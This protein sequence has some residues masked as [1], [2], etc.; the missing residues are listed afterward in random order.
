MRLKG[1]GSRSTITTER[2]LAWRFGCGLGRIDSPSTI[3]VAV[4][5]A[6]L[7]GYLSEERMKTPTVAFWGGYRTPAHRTPP[8]D[9]DFFSATGA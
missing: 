1:T 2:A 8:R 3:I 6:G 5:S 7:D 9:T 4:A